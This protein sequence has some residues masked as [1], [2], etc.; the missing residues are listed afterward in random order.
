MSIGAGQKVCSS[1]GWKCCWLPNFRGR[2]GSVTRRKL[3]WGYN[4]VSRRLIRRKVRLGPSAPKTK[5][6]PQSRSNFEISSIPVRFSSK[7]KNSGWGRAFSLFPLY[8]KFQVTL[9]DAMVSLLGRCVC[10]KT[11][12]PGNFADPDIFFLPCGKGF[13]YM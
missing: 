7:R 3:L 10:N 1:W 9:S 4:V 11:M 8:T 13:F 6:W 2:K 5:H 12:A